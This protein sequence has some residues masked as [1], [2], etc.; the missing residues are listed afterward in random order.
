M[1]VAE[2]LRPRGG[3]GLALPYLVAALLAGAI[4]FGG[5]GAE[6]PLN[7]GV[8]QAASG[9]VLLGLIIAH[10]Q[11]RRPLRDDAM[12]PVWLLVGLLLIGLVQVIPLPPAAWRGLAGR[13]LAESSLRLASAA[14]SWRPL[15]LDPEATRRSMAALLLPAAVMLAALSASTKG[16]GGGPAVGSRSIHRQQS[17]GRV[18]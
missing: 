7:N 3:Y 18:M 16:I 15:S 9:F 14:D 1:S 8:I 13:D 4:L 10:W 12:L 2:R 11:G 17:R 5:G 6:G